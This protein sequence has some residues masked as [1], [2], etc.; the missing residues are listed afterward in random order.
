MRYR[1]LLENN[2]RWA[3]E[4][5]AAD[6]DFFHRLAREHKPHCLFIGCSDARVPAEVITQ[7]MPGELFVHR[8][9]ANQALPT[10][11]NLHAALQ[12]AVEVLRVTD[13]IVCGHEGCGGVR[14]AMNTPA[15]P[16]VDT[17]VAGV[18]T[19]MRLHDKALSGVR[20]VEDR[21]VRLVELNVAEQV[22][23]LSRMPVVQ[24]AWAAGASLQIHGWVYG[25]HSGLLRDLGV[26]LDATRPTP[27]AA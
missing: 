24:A 11:P 12:Y 15:P 1:K 25:L 4:R 13:V 7:V 22:F 27:H 6:P 20:R 10:D 9:I 14:A 26:T 16:S 17:W 5:T 19:V 3:A 2:R 23:N 8:N 21:L 18:R